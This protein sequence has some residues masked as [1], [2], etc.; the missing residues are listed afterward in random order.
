MLRATHAAGTFGGKAMLL[1]RIRNV[2]LQWTKRWHAQFKTDERGTF[3]II[4]AIT[5][6]VALFVMG[7]GIDYSN[8]LRARTNIATALDASLLAAAR[9]LSI[10][11]VDAS[12]VNTR[13]NDYFDANLTGANLRDAHWGTVQTTLNEVVG[14][15]T[16]AVD[17]SVDTAFAKILNATEIP[18]T[19]DAE[20][21]YN[22]LDLEIAL[23]LDVTGS[24]GGQKMADMKAASKELIDILMSDNPKAAEKDK[25]RISVV[26]YSDM[27]NVGPFEE[28]VTGYSSG[29]SCVYER[30]QPHAFTDNAPLGKLPGQPA[31]DNGTL[32]TSWGGCGNRLEKP[33][34][35]DAQN[36]RGYSCGNPRLLP[37]TMEK[38]TLKTH[39]DGFGASG[40]TAG[41][42]GIQWGWNT[43]SPNWDTIWPAAS[44]PRAYN[45]KQNLKI[46]IVMTDGVLNTWFEN[47][48]GNSF[49]Q[50]RNLCSNIKDDG[51]LIYAVAFRAPGSAEQFMRDCATGGD[52]Y[53]NASSGSAL[54]RSFQE[55]A[56][57][58]RAL[59]L[60]S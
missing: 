1:G 21:T 44:K 30:P 28:A 45:A 11:D 18:M 14:T 6:P 57:R 39:I 55:I 8:A 36:Y 51:V 3:V 27:V 59:R 49:Q 47:N 54:R 9:D 13:V 20:A 32:D 23:V 48:Q 52:Y 35:N 37:M 22:I 16:G 31:D 56:N 17:V 38:D 2:T 43:L 53:F 7:A 19:I 42:I 50:G 4:A 25:V 26:P 34:A 5:M 41:H 46:M 40:C 60:S 58:I 24:M 15:L 33:I 12:Q 10:G 29:E